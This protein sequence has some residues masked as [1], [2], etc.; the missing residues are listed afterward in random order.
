M[1]YVSV[2]LLAAAAWLGMRWM[3]ARAE[4]AALREQVAALKRR[5]G[6][7]DAG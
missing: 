4:N 6:R 2:A 5:L 7:R 3:T 1:T